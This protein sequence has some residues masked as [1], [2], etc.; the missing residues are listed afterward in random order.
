MA[1]SINPNL[2]RARALAMKLLMQEGL[3]LAVV[4]NKCGVHRSTIYRWKL[5]WLDINKNVEFENKY[6]P[7][8]EAGKQFKFTSVSWLIPTLSSKPKV[9]PKAIGSE[10]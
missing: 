1:Y 3:P 6:R 2:A 10:I 5:K 4:A 8:R 9:S 7:N